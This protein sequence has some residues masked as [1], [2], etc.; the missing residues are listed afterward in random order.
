MTCLVIQYGRP[1]QNSLNIE[2][3]ELQLL[4]QNYD[5]RKPNIDNL[6]NVTE[7]YPF[8]QSKKVV[9]GI[10]GDCVVM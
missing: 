2:I 7:L 6:T 1:I 9:S 4:R 10:Q 8:L 5:Y 3:F